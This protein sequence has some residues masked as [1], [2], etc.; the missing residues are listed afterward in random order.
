M[1]FSGGVVVDG[2]CA[3]SPIGALV[4]VAVIPLVVAFDVALALFANDGPTAP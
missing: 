3:G 4:D 1:P 2:V